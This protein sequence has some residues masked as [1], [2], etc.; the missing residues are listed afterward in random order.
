MSPSTS[1]NAQLFSVISSDDFVN[2][3]LSQ[4]TYVNSLKARKASRNDVLNNSL[5][6]E[7]DLRR[8]LLF[9]FGKYEL[10]DGEIFE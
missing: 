7:L 4:M 2:D 6:R 10:E 9:K 5:L 1:M 3:F 8:K